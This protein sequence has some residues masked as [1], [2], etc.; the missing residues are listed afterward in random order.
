MDAA[1]QR[2]QV[3]VERTGD[4]FAVTIDGRAYRVDAV[5]I[6]GHEP[7]LLSLIVHRA[8]DRSVAAGPQSV[9]SYE[10]TV[11]PAADGELTVQVGSV[12]IRV[13]VDDRRRVARSLESGA[14]PAD[15]GPQR[16]A[17]SMPGKVVR[18]LVKAGEA[19]TARQPVVVIEAMKMENELR[20]GRDGIV[21]EIHTR[22]GASVDAGALLVVIR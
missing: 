16:L 14:G 9:R 21:A 5:R 10:V 6:D 12:P 11:S 4:G 18:V 1:G 13:R 15:A 8:V 22:E 2:S 7:M 3:G 19:V 17:A 20:A